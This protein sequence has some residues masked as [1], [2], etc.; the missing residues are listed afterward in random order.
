MR[1]GSLV[2]T[3]TMLLPAAAQAAAVQGALAAARSDIETADYSFKG[4]LV[5]VDAGGKRTSYDVSMKA[6]WFPKMLRVLLEVNSPADSRVHVLLE[7]QP[8][9]RSTILIAR[10]GDTKVSELPFDKWTEGP[11]GERF[12][13][14]DFLEAPY[15]WE[16]QRD[17]GEVKFGMRQCDQ[18]LSTPGA[19]DRTHF[20]E[21]KS[22]LD[23]GSGFPVYV[24]K[25]LKSSGNVKE[26]TYFGLR[27]TDGVWSARQVE[28]KIRGQGGSTLLI[29]DRGSP[30]AHLEL[31]DFSP[32][33]LTHF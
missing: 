11:V 4:R 16:G 15:F 17:L 12:S 19:S 14:E 7:M 20:T 18:L 21:V 27:R 5:R 3:L 23:H 32:A 22:W 9:G 31:N 6:H 10:P 28:G 29:I 26:F 30:K 2:L 25:T 33:Q 8:G 24:E 1:A 13:F